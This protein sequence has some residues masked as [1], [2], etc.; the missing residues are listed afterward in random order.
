MRCRIT[1][2]TM[3][4]TDKPTAT[5]NIGQL[6]PGIT[7]A[8]APTMKA[9]SAMRDPVHAARV[10]PWCTCLPRRFFGCTTSECCADCWLVPAM[11]GFLVSAD[12]DLHSEH[13]P[14]RTALRL[15]LPEPSLDLARIGARGRPG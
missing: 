5:Q 10:R 15:A 8:I 13:V 7:K 2:T 14:P 4:T 11:A 6:C 3:A 1:V 9:T 12:R